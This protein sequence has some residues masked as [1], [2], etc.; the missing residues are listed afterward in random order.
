MVG[1]IIER[2]CIG[3]ISLPS[4]AG[5][6]LVPDI[7]VPDKEGDSEYERPSERELTFIEPMVFEP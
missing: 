2:V 6:L 3:T 7:E 5:G 1:G 4:V